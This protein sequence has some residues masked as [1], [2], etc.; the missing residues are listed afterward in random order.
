[1]PPRPSQIPTPCNTARGASSVSRRV[2]AAAAVHALVVAAL[3]CAA[4]LL[5]D[6]LLVEDASAALQK[7]AGY[8]K[9]AAGNR[10]SELYDYFGNLRD[11]I[12]PLAIPIGT[13]GLVMGGTMY[14][15]GNPSAARLL[16]GVIV[17]VGLVLLSPV[18]VA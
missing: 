2:G 14:M 4:V 10:F 6:A 15:F 13:L 8:Q 17:G 11:A 12:V 1:M 18:L 3:F 16:F 5:A 9:T 7:L